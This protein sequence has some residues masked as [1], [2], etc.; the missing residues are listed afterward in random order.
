L[1]AFLSWFSRCLSIAYGPLG[2]LPKDKR[3]SCCLHRM[4]R[5]ICLAPAVVGVRCAC[6]IQMGLF[7]K[8][9]LSGLVLVL[10]AKTASPQ[11]SDA[12]IEIVTVDESG[13]A[14]PGVT[15]TVSRADTGLQRIVVT[16][17]VGL[18]RAIALPPG[19]YDMTLSR[20][21]F[22]TAVETGLT[23]R[24]GKRPGPLSRWA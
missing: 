11:I 1:G 14:L 6:D 24:V 16:D 8:L 21:G 5:D 20:P 13:A 7:R 12:V 3:G 18:A 2:R 10:A 19:T 17:T 15:V 23:L 22:Q 4:L 9:L